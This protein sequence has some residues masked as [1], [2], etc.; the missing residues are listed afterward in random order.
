MFLIY[1]FSLLIE[2]NNNKNSNNDVSDSD[3]D[4][5]TRTTN[6][7]KLMRSG[8]KAFEANTYI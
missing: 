2:G 6:D 1:F 7:R 8:K 3:S 5:N 4:N